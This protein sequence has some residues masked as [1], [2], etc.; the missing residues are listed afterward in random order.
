MLLSPIQIDT[1]RQNLRRI[2]LWIACG[3]ILFWG[4]LTALAQTLP[5]TA[6]SPAV[7][8]LDS[9]LSQAV[10]GKLGPDLFPLLGSDLPIQQV[11]QDG[12]YLWVVQR[13]PLPGRHLVHQDIIQVID[14][15]KWGT[16]RR[17]RTLRPLSDAGDAVTWPSD[18]I[19]GMA[20]GT[21]FLREGWLYAQDQSS[22]VP[23]ASY[24]TYRWQ[25]NGTFTFSGM[26]TLESP[27]TSAAPLQ[28][29]TSRMYPRGGE[30]FVQGK[31]F[32]TSALYDLGLP[33]SDGYLFTRYS[34]GQ[35]SLPLGFNKSSSARGLGFSSLVEQAGLPENQALGITPARKIHNTMMFFRNAPEWPMFEHVGSVKLTDGMDGQPRSVTYE[36]IE[37]TRPLH[38]S[39]LSAQLTGFLPE[40]NLH[41]PM[42]QL[43]SG[44]VPRNER[45]SPTLDLKALLLEA[46]PGRHQALIDF[47]RLDPGF[48]E[49]F[50]V[51]LRGIDL[52][53]QVTV[54]EALR[55]ISL[56]QLETRLE[57]VVEGY[58]NRVFAELS[59]NKL[60]QGSLAIDD[61]GQRMLI[62]RNRLK[63]Y[64]D[65]LRMDAFVVDYL[66]KALVPDLPFADDS[67][68]QFID[69]FSRS[70][71]GI[72]VNGLVQFIN[73]NPA[74]LVIELFIGCDF[75]D[76]LP[77]L[78]RSLMRS[79]G[80]GIRIEWDNRIYY[81]GLKVAAHYAG[82]EGFPRFEIAA[83]ERFQEHL[84][85]VQAGVFGAIDPVV[86][87]VEGWS[88]VRKSFAIGIHNKK[89]LSLVADLVA[90]GVGAVLRAR[91]GDVAILDRTVVEVIGR[92]GLQGEGDRLRFDQILSVTDLGSF[93][94]TPLDTLFEGLELDLGRLGFQSVIEGVVIDHFRKTFPEFNLNL[95]LHDHL[96]D[97]L[98]R[99][100]DFSR[101]TQGLVHE[102][103]GEHMDERLGGGTAPFNR[104]LTQIL[105][106]L[107]GTFGFRPGDDCWMNLIRRARF[108]SM[109][110]SIIPD[111]TFGCQAASAD[112][113]AIE[114]AAYTSVTE[115]VTSAIQQTVGQYVGSV[116]TEA[117]SGAGSVNTSF[118]AESRRTV[119]KVSHP[120][121]VELAAFRGRPIEHLGS[122]GQGD[123]IVSL[124][125]VLGG[126]TPELV[127]L[128]YDRVTA[129]HTVRSLGPVPPVDL[130]PMAS[131]DGQNPR[132]SQGFLGL[133][134]SRGFSAWPSGLFVLD[135]ASG[136]A[137]HFQRADPTLERLQVS[138]DRERAVL[139]SPRRLQVGL[140]P[141]WTDLDRERQ[142]HGPAPQIGL[143]P[144]EMSFV[145]G[146]RLDPGVRVRGAR[147]LVFLWKDE[148]GRVAAQGTNGFA[149][150]PGPT[151]AE[152]RYRLVVTNAHGSAESAP[153]R[154]TRRAP[155]LAELTLEADGSRIRGTEGTTLEI[156]VTGQLDERP[157]RYS[158]LR[159]SRT[160]LATTNRTL[161]LGPLAHGDSG[162]YS[163]R[164]D[165]PQ[166]GRVIGSFVLSVVGRFDPPA[167]FRPTFATTNELALLSRLFDR[168]EATDSR[169]GLTRTYTMSREDL[170]PY[171]RANP[172]RYR[173][174]L[175]D[176]GYPFIDEIPSRGDR[177]L[178]GRMLGN[179]LVKMAIQV[180][181]TNRWVL[182]RGATLDQLTPVNTGQGSLELILPADA[183]QEFYRVDPLP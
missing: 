113:A 10:P 165:G 180:E 35:G 172:S 72:L 38:A 117:L 123:R 1:L 30:L 155:V 44:M 19:H 127:E 80:D 101:I 41:V 53:R 5:T 73:W 126:E 144:A 145:P 18:G 182:R 26:R 40:A 36:W 75:P 120:L 157:L 134:S 43:V 3:S 100:M 95:S 74:T 78:A 49:N 171:N 160:I 39:P 178:S 79:W 77:A 71:L 151:W 152:G 125:Q 63:D 24:Y 8:I 173:G 118:S 124:L 56:R 58:F 90:D 59:L 16:P 179:H 115:S 137:V 143:P 128:S 141:L 107:L 21:V 23:A 116:V 54:R 6:P 131:N 156:P 93:L 104:L 14:V 98:L 52:D 167:N 66:F 47:L 161:R 67:V 70:E 46:I 133:V 15:S 139:W 94:T 110:L 50:D 112:L 150:T 135:A 7:S 17:V 149:V 174:F 86:A 64:F 4:S 81:E 175:G 153:L 28:T 129:R 105:N 33:L 163:V 32:S 76:D 99:A 158:L 114:Q 177:P 121:E 164:V 166:G 68:Q 109:V 82:F 12:P 88:G 2:H 159:S 20:L 34:M 106:D 162:R 142:V 48:D 11:W 103:L 37:L 132:L 154:L 122:H 89:L 181:A 136:R 57:G 13:E 168:V 183:D 140:L 9:S 60:V 45:L 176:R 25:T 42:S 84:L 108:M 91:T 31:V 65:A 97:Y 96:M 169:T 29:V 27:D 61:F 62:L 69:R 146:E 55:A 102:V 130:R 147:P 138:T 148:A 83:R 87:K 51:Y 170:P 119:A 22:F 92:F 85:E 111:P